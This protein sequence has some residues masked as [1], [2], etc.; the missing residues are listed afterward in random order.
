MFAGHAAQGSAGSV[1]LQ[2]FFKKVPSG[3]SVG[4]QMVC[5]AGF[6]ITSPVIDKNP[7]L[8]GPLQ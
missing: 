1:Q 2:S 7:F 5:Q 3:H 4:G 6:S 8:P